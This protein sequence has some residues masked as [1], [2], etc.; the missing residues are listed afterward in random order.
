[1]HDNHSGIKLFIRLQA[2]IDKINYLHDIIDMEVIEWNY[3][4]VIIGK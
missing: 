3:I 4:K 2:I 1:M